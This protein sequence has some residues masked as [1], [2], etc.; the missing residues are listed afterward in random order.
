MGEARGT[1]QRVLNLHADHAVAITESLDRLIEI[2]KFRAPTLNATL[3]ALAVQ[4]GCSVHTIHLACRLP[5][6][7]LASCLYYAHDLS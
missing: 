5:I 7:S 4:W 2:Y 1:E 6:R 3:H